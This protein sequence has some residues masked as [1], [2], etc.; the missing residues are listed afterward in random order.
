MLCFFDI[1]LYKCKYFP[2]VSF[3]AK[4]V[5]VIVIDLVVLGTL[6]SFDLL[7]NI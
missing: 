2:L 1:I 3:A 5:F 7:E 6:V 4:D